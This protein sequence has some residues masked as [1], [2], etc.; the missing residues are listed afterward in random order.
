MSRTMCILWDEDNDDDSF[1]LDQHG[2]FEFYCASMLLQFGANQY[3][4]LHFNAA[5]LVA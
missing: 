3:L 1:V 4:L 2:K 5:C